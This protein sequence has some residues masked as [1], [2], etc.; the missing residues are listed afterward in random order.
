MPQLAGPGPVCAN[1]GCEIDDGSTDP[2]TVWL[3]KG[4]G[5]TVTAGRH[6]TRAGQMVVRLWDSTVRTTVVGEGR[7]ASIAEASAAALND[8]MGRMA[9]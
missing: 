3:A 5:R 8:L 1:C 7:G 2:L 9:S 6:P 4:P